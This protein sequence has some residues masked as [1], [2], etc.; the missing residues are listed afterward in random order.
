MKKNLNCILAFAPIACLLVGMVLSI[1]SSIIGSIGGEGFLVIIG[2]IGSLLGFVLVFAGAILC[3]GMIV[4]FGI[5]VCKRKDLEVGMKVLWCVLL[6]FF[7]L[8][9][10]PICYFV[11]LRKEQ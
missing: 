5:L 10:F 3:L 1:A 11:V 8:F 2:V 6:Y 9:T 7:N 4:Y